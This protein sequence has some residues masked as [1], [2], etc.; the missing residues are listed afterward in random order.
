M[1]FFQIMTVQTVK[2][3]LGCHPDKSGT[4]LEYLVDQT[5]RE[6]VTGGIEPSGLGI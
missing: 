6:F 1:I 3:V 2:P 5:V 4:V